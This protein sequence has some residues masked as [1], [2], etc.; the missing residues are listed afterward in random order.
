MKAKTIVL[1]IFYYLFTSML[2]YAAISKLLTFQ[3]F[4]A[5]MN[6]QPFSDKYT[7]LL[8]WGIPI[9]EIAASVMMLTI[10]FRRLGLYFA[11]AMMVCFTIYI[12]LVKMHFYD[13]LPCSCGGVIATFSWTQHLFFNLFFVAIGGIGIY[14]EYGSK[15]SNTVQLKSDN[16]VNNL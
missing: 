6:R 10:P 3:V 8:A 1:L 2:L 13:T 11:T 14:L 5:Q 16:V 12:I 15:T 4:V 9:V 7:P